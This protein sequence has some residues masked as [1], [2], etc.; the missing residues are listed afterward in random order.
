MKITDVQLISFRVRT[1]GSPT[2]WGYGVRG[3]KERD[4]VQRIAKIVTDEGAEGYFANDWMGYFHNPTKAEVDNVVKPLLVGQDPLDREKL[5]HWMMRHRGFSEGLVGVMDCALWDLA[6]RMA[7]MPV[8]KMLGGARD[9]IKA[10]ASTGP[11]LGPPDVYAQHALECKRRG[12]KAYKVHAY[13][14][15]DPHKQEPAPGRP[16]FPKED[17]E[18]CRAVREAVGEDMV[19]MLDPWGVYTYEEALWVGKELEKLGFYFLEHPMDERLLEP[20]RRLCHALDIPVCGPELAPGSQYTRAEWVLQRACDIGRID[21][22]FGGIT[23]CM[24]AVHMYESL[25]VKCE[26]HVGGFANSQV[27][28]ATTEDTCEFYERGLLYP[29]EDYDG[30]VAPFLKNKCDPM[31]DQGYVHVPKGPGLGLDIN[32]DYINDNLVKE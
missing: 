4:V 13:I 12:Y 5:W 21:I 24:K 27:L 28:A 16:A 25:G 10:Y 6:G 31:D 17:V 19:L 14:Y 2:R 15:W 7:G 23:G 8:H 9:R 22:N 1:R 11:N 29:G 30:F 20:Y 3:G 26:I 18:V 32:W